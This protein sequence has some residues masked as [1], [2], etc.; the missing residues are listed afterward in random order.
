VWGG[1]SP[2]LAFLLR[3]GT[4]K[5]P[6]TV[7]IYCGIAFAASVVVFQWL[8]T[9]S[10]IFR[11]F[12]VRD[13]LDLLKACV[14]IAA[15]SAVCLFSLTRLD[16]A[17]RSI[18]VLHLFFLASGLLAARLLSRLRETRRESSLRKAPN[19]PVQHVLVV[20]A[21]RLAW[22]FSKLVEE[23]LPGEYQ[24]VAVL[25]ERPAL[26]R[27]SLNGYPIVGSP[28]HIEKVIDEYGL[29][30]IAIDRVVVGA[31]PEDISLD[32]WEDVSSVCKARH[33]ELD[34][35]PNAFMSGLFAER[36]TVEGEAYSTDRALAN[37]ES[38]E[39]LLRGPFWEAKRLID[40][41]IAAIVAVLALPV[42]V[43]VFA[44]ALLDVGMPVIF[45]QQRV[46]RNGRP[47]Y[48]YKFRTLQTRHGRR[49]PA[50]HEAQ[51]PSAIGRFLRKTRLDELPQLWNILSGDMSLIG[52]RPLLPVDQPSGPSIRLTIRPG[53]S[54]WAQVCGGK[55]ISVEEKNALDEWYI[56][57]ASLFL[58][59]RIVLRTIWMLFA[60]DRRDEGAIAT[61]LAEKFQDELAS[62]TDG[63]PAEKTGQIH[64]FRKPIPRAP[65]QLRQ[66]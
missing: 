34:V 14:L 53:L 23:L 50:S 4:I 46:G 1:A 45:W 41:T 8:Q 47:L 24:I 42:S 10:P 20:Q 11:Y 27:R 60:G 9:S 21:T 59:F 31:K 25:D 28:A 58:D 62:L 12:S 43:F 33:I 55:L 6:E 40:F 51:K 13:A 64:V 49:T 18:P 17:P 61:A 57:R 63:I 37:V 16:D 19:S 2:L 39:A 56:R 36:G 29:H 30:G 35:L 5:S 26:R 22:F 38:L 32:V 52:P 3:D 66:V 44:F 15:L 65:P 7:L 48:L 54:G